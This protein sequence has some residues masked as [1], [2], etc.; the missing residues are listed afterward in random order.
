MDTSGA[1]AKAMGGPPV[2]GLYDHH[3]LSPA[4]ASTPVMRGRFTR[5]IYSS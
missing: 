3:T 1:G 5:V 4:K 2:H